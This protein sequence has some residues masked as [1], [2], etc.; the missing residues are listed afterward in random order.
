MEKKTGDNTAILK[1]VVYRLNDILQ[2]QLSI[3]SQ[4]ER[5]NKQEEQLEEIKEA[6]KKQ[7]EILNTLKAYIIPVIFILCFLVSLIVYYIRTK[8]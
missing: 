1:E 8:L 7:T 5:L 3:E 2:N 6:I 4:S